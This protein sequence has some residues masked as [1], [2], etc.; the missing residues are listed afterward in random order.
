MDDFLERL[1]NALA[2]IEKIVREKATQF[3]DIK[4]DEFYHIVGTH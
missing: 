3:I 4:M 2:K 1:N